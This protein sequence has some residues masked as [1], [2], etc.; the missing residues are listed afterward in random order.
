MT[1]FQ[2]NP[3]CF[4]PSEI[5]KI[6]KVSPGLQREWRRKGQ[7]PKNETG[8]WTRAT[9]KEVT[10]IAITKMIADLGISIMTARETAEKV[11]NG[12][13][14]ELVSRPD[15]VRINF[16]PTSG[17]KRDRIASDVSKQLI[18]ALMPDKENAILDAIPKSGW[19]KVVESDVWK[20]AL[21][22]TR[23]WAWTP[24]EDV[25]SHIIPL[26][27]LKSLPDNLVA[28]TLFDNRRAADAIFRKA[29]LPLLEVDVI[30]VDA[31]EGSA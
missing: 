9:L 31:D 25:A 12:V 4:T 18:S 1:S 27:S 21:D 28:M 3:R 29:E 6:A 14:A 13:L 30:D 2:F 15:A 19:D 7:L 24:R 22:D 16:P 8:G 10:T 23:F 5:E 26:R 20:R 17:A 11:V